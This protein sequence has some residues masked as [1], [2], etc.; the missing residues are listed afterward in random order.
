[1]AD[2]LVFGL[3]PVHEDAETGEGLARITHALG[4]ALGRPVIEHRAVSPSAL[5]FAWSSG[6]VDLAWT[7]PTLALTAPELRGA[8]P[9]VSS[10]RE[11]VAFYHGV[12]FV[13]RDSPIL[14][15]RGCGALA[16]PGSPPPRRAATSS[17]ASRSPVTASIRWIS[18][19]T[20]RSS[21]RT[22]PWRARCATGRPTS[23]RPSPSSR[24]ATR[25]VR[26]YAPASR[27]SRAAGGRASSYPPR[28]SPPI[29][30]WPRARS[31]ARW[32]SIGSA[33]PCGRSPL[34]APA[35]VR[36]VLG[37]DSF[38]AVDERSLDD[39]RRQLEDA[40]ALGVFG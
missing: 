18:S 28:A 2:E 30:S 15:P 10:V 9:A 13:R 16:R 29:C 34:V 35:A 26:S 39:L 27:T 36:H 32:G 21:A 22:A 33:R 14:S 4:E 3:V 38:A 1:M 31:P 6:V 25:R 23:A 11:G 40:R 8:V 24:A 17:R 37:A 19:P 5:A 12:L 20:S 7:S